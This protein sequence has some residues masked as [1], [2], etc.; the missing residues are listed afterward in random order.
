[1]SDTT[2]ATPT[3]TAG[4]LGPGTG[5]APVTTATPVDTSSS[6]LIVTSGASRSNYANNVNTLN[7]ATTNLASTNKNDPSIVNFLNSSKMPSDYNSRATMAKQNGIENYTGSAA[8]NTQ[9]LGIL[10]GDKKDTTG[11]DTTTKTDTTSTDTTSTTDNTFSGPYTVDPNGN[12]TRND[13]GKMDAGLVQSYKDSLVQM[14]QRVSDAKNTLSS[15]LSTLQNDPAAA[16]AISMIEAK[17]DQ[18]LELMKGK[19]NMVLGRASTAIAAYGGLG[20]MSNDFMSHEQDL[21]IT[22]LSD[23]ISKESSAIMTATAAYKKGDLAAFDSASKQLDTVTKDKTDAI[24]KLLKSSNDAVKTQQAQQK[25]DQQKITQ[26]QTSDIKLSTAVAG[27]IADSIKQN[28]LTDPKQIKDYIDG[29]A[30]AQGITNTAVL[31]SAVSKIQLSNANT[32]ST[33]N[34]R[35]QPPKPTGSNKGGV[36]GAYKY[37]PDDISSYASVMDKGA[38]IDGTTYNGRGSDGYVDPGTYVASYND[39]I[40][41]GGTPKGFLAKFPAKTNVNPTDYKAIPQALRPVAK[42]TS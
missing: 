22:R 2:I 19:N 1:M 39:W 5:P 13:G 25:L 3:G 38:T 6:P 42:K 41:N 30:K 23:I 8:Q 10:Q 12:L 18:Q 33:I 17:F 7:T 9:L 28:G 35:N 16:S 14:D 24:N 31:E 20:Q 34:K 40:K 37:T 4:P 11:G 29:V 15:A 27:S 36:D 26:Q 21:A 32:E